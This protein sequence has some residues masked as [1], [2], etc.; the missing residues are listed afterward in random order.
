MSIEQEELSGFTNSFAEEPAPIE[1][2]EA[3]SEETPV[4]ESEPAQE[5]EQEVQETE[6]G[7]PEPEPV[8]EYITKA[9]YEALQQKYDA[10][11]RKVYGKYGELHRDLTNIPRGGVQFSKDK[12]KRLQGEYPELAEIIA[13]DLSEALTAGSGFDPSQLES[14]MG[15]RVTQATE[16][17]VK[18]IQELSLTIEH[19]D[20]RKIKDSPEFHEWVSALPADELQR[21]NSSYDA[22]YAAQVLA[23]F[24]ASRAKEEEPPPPSAKT[25]VIQAAV[26]PKGSQVPMPATNSEYEEFLRATSRT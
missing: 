7:E 11:I 18:Q 1:E 16:P 8:P 19:P 3:A 14:V 26:K 6:Q 4:E 23:Q 15:Q 2:I 20:W 9:D 21:I 10:E 12:L 5:P 25:K 24:K 22:S 17:L 13:E